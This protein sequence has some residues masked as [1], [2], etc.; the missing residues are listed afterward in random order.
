[1]NYNASSVTENEERY[2]SVKEAIKFL[3][4]SRGFLYK[5]VNQGI[6]PQPIKLGK[7]S[8]WRKSDLV[9][10]T[11]QIAKNQNPIQNKGKNEIT[12][13]KNV[14]DGVEQGALL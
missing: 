10:A 6:Y 4:I 11:E 8:L 13:T 12:F 5:L 1:M 9:S 14:V 7:K 2:L 3:S